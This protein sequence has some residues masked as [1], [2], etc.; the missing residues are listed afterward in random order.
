RRRLTLVTQGLMEAQVKLDDAVAA[1]Q[2]QEDED[3]LNPLPTLDP[4]DKGTGGANAKSLRSEENARL[5]AARAVQKELLNLDQAIFDA[6]IDGEVRTA[7]QIQK[8]YQLAVDKI[9]SETEE[10]YLNLQ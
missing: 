9:A 6:R 7:E 8:N 1:R 5:N 3:R 2:K 4:E 10:R